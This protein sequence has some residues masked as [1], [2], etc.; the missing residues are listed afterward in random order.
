MSEQN[1]VEASIS[2]S[3]SSYR[4]ISRATLR[5]RSSFVLG[6]CMYVPYTSN[7]LFTIGTRSSFTSCT[8]VCLQRVVDGSA[9]TVVGRPGL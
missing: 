2:G 6:T 7:K 8:C 3:L 1:S 4:A 5:I 9:S